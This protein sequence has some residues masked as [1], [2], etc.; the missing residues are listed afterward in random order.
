VAI[1]YSQGHHPLSSALKG[2][3]FLLYC[4]H[5]SD[6]T[7]SRLDRDEANNIP[8]MH[9][10]A[11]GSAWLKLQLREAALAV[12]LLL[13]SAQACCRFPCS[14]MFAIHTPIKVLQLWSI[15]RCIFASVNQAPMTRRKN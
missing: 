1:N 5:W 8:R 4:F 12:R 6:I 3:S 9:G 11:F 13:S 10:G 2:A 7:T 15:L 14:L